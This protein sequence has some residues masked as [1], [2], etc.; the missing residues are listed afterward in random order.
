ML[1]RVRVDLDLFVR[2]AGNED[3]EHLPNDR[4]ETGRAHHVQLLEAL[5]VVRLARGAKGAKDLENILRRL[6]HLHVRDVDDD[7]EPP[8]GEGGRAG[9][10]QAALTLVEPELVLDERL[11]AAALLHE[12]PSPHVGQ[13]TV[14]DGGVVATVGVVEA[15]QLRA[16]V[17]GGGEMRRAKGMRE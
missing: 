9:E 17:L 3:L 4:E 10:Q 13:A 5:G 12:L 15:Q 11:H 7:D 2:V 14:H 6:S 1:V 16:V 8:A